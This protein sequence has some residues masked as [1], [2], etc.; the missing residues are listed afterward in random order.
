M[1]H[2]HVVR[3]VVRSCSGFEAAP[4]RQGLL[5]GHRIRSLV[6]GQDSLR[7][8]PASQRAEILE[9][10]VLHFR[11]RLPAETMPATPSRACQIAG[12]SRTHFYDIKDAFERYGRDGLAPKVPMTAVDL[13]HERVPAS[14]LQAARRTSVG[15]NAVNLIAP[16]ENCRQLR[17]RA[18]V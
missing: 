3:C 12:I 4:C 7:A 9:G 15:A 2:L 1:L 5:H 14:S 18:K 17:D 10:R 6:A 16:Q 11:R 8:L 13:L